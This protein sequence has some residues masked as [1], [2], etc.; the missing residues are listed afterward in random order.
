MCPFAEILVSI[1]DYMPV[2]DQLRFARA[3]RRMLEMVYDDSRWVARLRSLG[4]WDEAHAR[5]HFDEAMKRRRETMERAATSQPPGGSPSQQRAS[6]GQRQTSTT[7]FDAGVEEER[8][9]KQMADMRDGF[10][11][12]TLGGGAAG[13][14]SPKPLPTDPLQD[15][16]A[17]LDVLKNVR[18]IRG[19]ARQEYGKIY[20]ALGPFYYD[21]V[22]AKSHAE[23]I[24]FKAFRD[25]ERQAQMLAN[26]HVFARSDWAAGW[27]QREERLTEMSGIFESAVLREFEQGYEFWDVDG[28]MRKYAHVLDTLNGGGAGVELFL[29]KHPIF[30]DREVMANSMDCI[31]QAAADDISLEPSRRFLEVLAKKVNEQGMVMEKIFPHPDQVFWGFVDKVTEDVIMEYCTPL[32]D[33]A[34]ERSTAV[35]LKAVSGLFEQGLQFYR[36]LNPPTGSRT[37]REEK[38]KGMALKIFEPHLDLYLQ[39]ELDFFTRHAEQEVG[40]WEK[41]LSAQ[42]ASVE[43]FYMSNFNRQADKTD[44]LSSFKKVVMMPVTVLPSLPGPFGIAKPATSLPT[45]GSSA[46]WISPLPSRS[47]TPGLGPGT[48]GT[49]SPLPDK[50]P[51]DELAAKAALMASRLEG[52][53]SLFSIEVALNLVHAAKASL[54]RAA[55]FIRL[56]GQAGGEA[57]EQ[58]ETIF[59]VMLRILGSR[60]VKPG[61]DKAVEHLSQYNPREVSDHSGRGEGGGVAPLVTFIELVNVGDLISQMI[62]VFYEQQLAQPKIA[63][64]ND[65]LDPAGLAKKKFEQ[66]LDES[67]AAGLNK[68]IDVLMDEVEYL[69]ATMQLPTDYNPTPPAATAAEKRSSVFSIPAMAS[70]DPDIGPT[71]TAK[72]IVELVSSHTRMLVGSTEKTMLDVFNSEVGLR[73]FTAVCKHLKRQRIS[74]DGAIKLIADMNLYFEYIRTLRNQDLLAYFKALRELSQIYLI[75]PRHAKE[76]AT[77]IAD[78]DR[79]GGIF[80]AEEVY[81]YA[82][83]RADWYQVRKDVERAMYGLE[84]SLM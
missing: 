4:R 82:E 47:Q 35:Y 53:K 22:K 57:R 7:L 70:P 6:T 2:A 73:L 9:R 79:F 62:D 43:S 21:L 55:V 71:Q 41:Q 58:C 67:V 15:P 25:P 19:H 18:S 52:I 66:M 63:D 50:V 5:Q 60:H 34:R 80:R 24:V 32:F 48:E 56:G 13:G 31:N 54:G 64:R 44:F 8:Q 72:R 23:P 51:T 40:S 84:C 29:Q 68:G 39:D 36:T 65:F 42:D 3:S 83:R 33:E 28:R 45:N 77:I 59:V 37:H 75:D 49:S 14:A 17:V 27:R 26:L 69:C 81:E 30:S 38:A 74:T 16:E 1:L 10:K 78:G 76:M 12:M 61:F 20:G 11:T 46:P